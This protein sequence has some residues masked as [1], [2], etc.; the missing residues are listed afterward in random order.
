[1]RNVSEGE[2]QARPPPLTNEGLPLAWWVII[3]EGM[4][5]LRVAVTCIFKEQEWQQI[6]IFCIGSSTS[7]L[8]VLRAGLRVW[9]IINVLSSHVLN[10]LKGKEVTKWKA[11]RPDYRVLNSYV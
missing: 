2:A 10:V 5:T 7:A 1:M 11:W 9:V 6:E 4:V 3:I 8:R